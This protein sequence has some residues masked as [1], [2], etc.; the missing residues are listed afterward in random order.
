[1]GET[2]DNPRGAKRLKKTY[3]KQFEKGQSEKIQTPPETITSSRQLGGLFA[4][5]NPEALSHGMLEM[6]GGDG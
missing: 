4:D 3:S 1:M 5:Y 2:D 6:E